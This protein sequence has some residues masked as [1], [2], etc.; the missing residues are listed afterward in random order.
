MG[1]QRER[2][3]DAKA[4]VSVQCRLFARYAE[5]TGVSD[6][7]LRLPTGATV[8]D[9]VALLRTRIA[10]GDRL[11]ERPMVAVN[12]AHALYGDVLN[13]GDELALLP[14]LAGG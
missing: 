6:H 3:A 13:N 1:A 14:P 5:M 11:P 8:A 2:V 4:P 7:T 10:H 9:A 12:H